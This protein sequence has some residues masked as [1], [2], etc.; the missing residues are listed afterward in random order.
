MV[1]VVPRAFT[2]SE[3]ATIRERLMAVA[4]ESFARQG[5]RRTTVDELARAAGISKGA[6]YGFF[7]S[8]EA[9][10]LALVEEHEIRAQ[11]EIEAA[12]REDPARGLEVVIEAAMHATERNPLMAVAMSDEGRGLLRAM[13]DEQREAFMA[14]DARLVD[15]V[16]DLLEGAGVSLDVSPRVLLA[17]LRSLVMVGWHR[18]DIDEGLLDELMAWLTPTLRAAML[19][20]GNGIGHG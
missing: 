19:P 5:V 7:D 15:R 10:F 3:S 17:L 16:L 13:S 12:I 14:R 9:L 4:A 1:R 6:F 2:S 11:A 20:D 8:K 18:H